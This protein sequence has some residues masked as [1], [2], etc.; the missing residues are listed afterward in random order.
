MKPEHCGTPCAIG[1]VLRY[2]IEF[3]FDNRCSRIS[4]PPVSPPWMVY[5]QNPR[6][7]LKMLLPACL[8]FLFLSLPAKR[9][10]ES[11][12]RILFLLFTEHK[13]HSVRRPNNRNRFSF[14]EKNNLPFPVDKLVFRSFPRYLGSGGRLSLLPIPR[15]S[16]SDSDA[17]QGRKSDT[18]SAPTSVSCALCCSVCSVYCRRKRFASS[19]VLIPQMRISTVRRLCSVPHKRSIR[20][21]LCA[22]LHNPCPGGAYPVRV[23]GKLDLRTGRISFIQRCPT[24]GFRRHSDLKV[25]DPEDGRNASEHLQDPVV[26]S[27]ARKACPLSCSRLPPTCGNRRA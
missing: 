13:E 14:T 25:V 10:D 3:L 6:F 26:A 23:H 18:S 21:L 2:R 4:F 15:I 12:R 19:V 11:V 17:G 16:R 9:G 24:S 22:D 1:V 7:W 8:S 5:R 27:K 20:H